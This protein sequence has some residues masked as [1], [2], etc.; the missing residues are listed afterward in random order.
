MDCTLLTVMEKNIL[1]CLCFCQISIEPIVSLTREIPFGLFRSLIISENIYFRYMYWEKYMCEYVCLYTHTERGKDREIEIGRD[2]FIMSIWLT[3]L[4]RLRNHMMPST[5]WR[6]RKAF[7]VISIWFYRPEN[8]GSQESNVIQR[9][10]EEPCPNSRQAERGIKGWIS[11]F[12][13][14]ILFRSSII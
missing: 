9:T 14:F 1:V 10:E 12:F 8:Q 5:S 4:W 2:I 3:K 11:F 6:P 13:F 7:G